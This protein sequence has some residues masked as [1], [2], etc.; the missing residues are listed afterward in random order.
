M[1]T[2]HSSAHPQ[3][4][5]R[6]FD[7]M[8]SPHV[9]LTK[10]GNSFVR[11]TSRQQISVPVPLPSSPFQRVCGILFKVDSKVLEE[12]LDRFVNNAIIPLV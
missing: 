1:W 3:V 7:G 2:R 5:P 9:Q 11:S 10:D 12:V 4:Q 6:D 8:S